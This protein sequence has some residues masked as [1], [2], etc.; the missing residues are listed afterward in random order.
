MT[1]PLPENTRSFVLQQG[2]LRKFSNFGLLFN[3]Y[4][5]WDKNWKKKQDILKEILSS[6]TKN[7]S[8]LESYKNRQKMLLENYKTRGYH[9]ECF[10]M[11]TD[12]RFISGLGGAHVLETG[13]TLH[14]LYGFPF[15]PA[16]GVKGLARS[17]A[18]KVDDASSIEMLEVFGSEDKDRL[19]DS[20]REGRVV[21]LDGVPAEF[22][23]IEV[24]IMNPHYGDY[25]QGNK[26]PADYLDPNPITFLVVAPGKAF[27][28][29]LF[30]RDE[31]LLEKSVRWL[32]GGLIELGAG[33][34]TNV[35]YGYF[36]EVISQGLQEHKEAVAA[37]KE[38]DDLMARFNKLKLQCNPEK[39]LGFIKSVGMEEIPFPGNISFKGM[40]SVINVGIVENL[41]K[42]EVSSDVLKAVAGKM[43][44]VIKPHKKW[45][46]KKHERYKKLCLMAGVQQNP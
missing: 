17:Y 24:D 43:L 35:G 7:D 4:I 45:D 30:S 22:P 44:E 46:D 40:E 3:K 5:D 33:G 41:E 29:S 2:K 11:A 21:F 23:E 38:D 39:F 27:M 6:Y 15:L 18:E 1:Y 31:S 12:Y 14:S 19:S 20:N 34:K 10:T 28:F 25:Y 32:K 8:F 42:L 37:S 26:P 36:K 9:V 13:L 16:S